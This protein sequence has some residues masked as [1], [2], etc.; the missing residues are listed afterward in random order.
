M[1][2]LFI[3]SEVVPFAKTGGLADVASA[4]PKAIKAI[5][6]DIRIL[7]PRYKCVSSNAMSARLA[8]KRAGRQELRV[9][10]LPVYFFE[11][12]H[13]SKRDE[14]Y[15]K[16]G[17]DYPDNCE[18]FLAFCQSV[19]AFLKRIDWQPDIIHCNDWQTA[20]VCLFIKELRKSD[21]SFKRCATVF[22]IHNLA[23]Q[24][25][26]PR[27]KFASTGLPQ[28]LEFY[29]QLSFIKAGLLY[30]DVVNTVSEAYAQEIK[31]KEY[32][33]GLEKELKKRSQ[34][35]YGILN[36]LD[37]DVWNP[38]KDPLIK[39]RYSAGTISL[40]GEN[41]LELQRVNNLP[42]D[43]NIPLLGI[44]SRLADQ[45]GFDL[46]EEVMEEIL[47]LGC[48]FVLLGTGEPKYHK[49]FETLKK[50]YPRQAGINLGFNSVFSL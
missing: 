42:Q 46:L 8:A 24:G 10:D 29:D 1:K 50:K 17:Q 7:M 15:V 48:Q 12:E 31:T 35:L 34:D 6:H 26:F 25:N 45:K 9:G 43:K 38:A 3:S 13:F 4:L 21:P 30:A 28:T 44:V 41:K 19:E 14:L 49:F 37:Y 33:C 22:S 40:R 2:I 23:Y 27:E 32:G 20:L 5:G 18:A 36:G 16:N 39:R 11:D 47:A